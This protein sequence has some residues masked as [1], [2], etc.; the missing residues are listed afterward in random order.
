MLTTLILTIAIAPLLGF[1]L[2]K[3]EQ[4]PK[5]DRPLT[6]KDAVRQRY[7]DWRDRQDWTN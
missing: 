4:R 3:L 5:T 6:P 7:W 2:F 1:V